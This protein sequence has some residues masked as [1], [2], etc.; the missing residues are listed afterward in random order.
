MRTLCY[1]AMDN[2]RTFIVLLPLILAACSTTN[3][4]NPP[5]SATEQLLIST[6]ADR[7]AEK[8]ALTIPPKT[9]VFIDAATFD[10][11]DSK[12]AIGAIR[13]SMLKQGVYFVD[14]RKKAK[15]IIEIRAG[16]LSTDKDQFLVGIPSFNIPVPFAA[17]GL[18]FPEIALYKSDTQKGVAK[19]AFI[20][21]DAK[22]GKPV[23]VEDPQYGFSH[24]TK[25]T[26]LIFVN[27]T[28]NDALPEED[29]D[30]VTRNVDR[31]TPNISQ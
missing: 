6:A 22:T 21:Y 1:I 29:K 5:R 23:Q 8:L 7:A 11:I 12:Y 24:N 14:D 30:T 16:A 20:G 31:V 18:G 13:A 26:V 2:L 27:W 19:F 28:D 9:P 15:T 4:T 25:Q 17:S 3:E 10:G